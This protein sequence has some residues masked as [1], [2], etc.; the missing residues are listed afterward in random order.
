MKKP[1]M[2]TTLYIIILSATVIKTPEINMNLV[3]SFTVDSLGAC[4]GISVQNGKIYLYGD[5]EVGV[6]REYEF[7]N[8]SIFYVTNEIKLTIHDSDIINH[9]T[10]F[11]IHNKLPTFMGN[12][13]RLNKEGTLWKAAIYLIDWEGMKKTH[14]LDNNLLSTID[15]DI[16]IQ[17][18]RPEYVQYKNKWYVATADYG[19]KLNEVRLY[20]PIAL[21]KCKKTTEKNVLYKKFSCTPWVQNLHWLPKEKLL[22]LIQNQTEGRGWR[23]T[24][25]DL[26]K[27]IISGKQIVVKEV[28]IN[29]KKDELEG[30]SFLDNS[31][32][33]IAV[34]SS[35][36]NNITIIN[37]KIN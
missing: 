12:S 29:E 25:V 16:C 26:E 33:G 37:A 11:A 23:F 34:T 20:D 24:Y 22:V 5:R 15:D 28:D 31:S 4:Q 32:K 35:R 8:D 10:G 7:K 19:G 1:W 27:S 17:G 13:V 2:I 36:R 6:I 9:P 18:T 3:K 21:A 14:T 30:F